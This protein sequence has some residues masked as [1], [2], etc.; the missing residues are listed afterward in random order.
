MMKHRLIQWLTAH[1]L[2]TLAGVL[3]M[4][5]VLGGPVRRVHPDYSVEHL[6]PVWASARAGYDRSRAQFRFED[7]RAAVFVRAPDLFTREGLSR[8][9]ALENDLAEIPDVLEVR[10]PA[11]IR[12]IAPRGDDVVVEKLFP[13][14][15]LPQAELAGRHALA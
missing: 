5:T 2:A 15:D 1:P 7:A 8:L 3:A 4:C 9:G 11:S 12:V 14:P 6:F 10:G 13:S